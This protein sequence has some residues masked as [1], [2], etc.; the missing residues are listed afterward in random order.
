MAKKT[1]KKATRS[2]SKSASSPKPKVMKKA[3]ATGSKKPVGKFP[4][5][6]AAAARPPV[7][8]TYRGASQTSAPRQLEVELRVDVDESHPQ[9]P[10]LNRVSYDLFENF[11]NNNSQWQVHRGSW[12]V[13]VPNAIVHSHEV[14]IS[15]IAR[16]WVGSQQINVNIRIMRMD[17]T[18]LPGPVEL[19]IEDAIGEARFDCEWKS[20]RF[21][22]VDLEV[23]ICKSVNSKKPILPSY[24]L[25][26]HN[27]RPDEIGQ[28]VLTIEDAYTEAGVAIEISS[29]NTV[30]DDSDPQFDSWSA[31]ELHE[32][33]VTHFEQHKD[34]PQWKLWG[35]LAGMYENPGVGG[36]MFDAAAQF[37]GAGK[38]PERQGF[39]VFRNHSWFNSL[40]AGTPSTQAQAEAARKYLYTWVHEAGHAFNFLHSWDKTRPDALSWMNYDW[41]YDQRNGSDTFW[42]RFLFTFDDSELLHLRH[43]NRSAVIMGGDSW[44]SGGHLESEVTEIVD[45]ELVS[46]EP[47]VEVLLRSAEWFQFLEPV[48]IEIRLR[49]RTSKPLDV[50]TNV[51]PEFGSVTIMIKSPDG[52]VKQYQPLMCKLVEVKKRKLMSET[53]T[54]TGTDRYSR[55]ID[56]TFGE[57]GFYFD[58]PGRYTI[59]AF[60]QG[61]DGTIIPSNS[62]HISVGYPLTPQNERLAQDYFTPEVGLMIYLNGSRSPRLEKALDVLKE[63]SDMYA[64]DRLAA[65]TN[66]VIAEA[67]GKP[68]FEVKDNKLVQ[69]QGPKP[70]EALEM[71]DAAMAVFAASDQESANLPHRRLVDQRSEFWKAIGEP[72]KVKAEETVLCSI[73]KKRGVNSSVIKDIQKQK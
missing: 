41:K 2:R 39:A 27:N 9:S 7:S 6:L 54:Q 48:S 20:H 55:L 61:L 23:D 14:A 69:K 10:T 50:D 63:V 44:A 47:P 31:A 16:S 15:G 46:G 25:H 62:H 32:A 73:L 13:D 57:D 24:D 22:N 59:R 60:Y 65:K 11:T 40:V 5:G 71:T 51:D 19:T 8:G 26:T 72:S 37:G 67:V 18:T 38:A 49:N 70:E 58:R 43:G 30:I 45:M 4:P 52:A 35:L 66:S 42:K 56:L 3:K 21:R 28:R 33:M 12:I 1:R 64:K 68:F 17:S 29:D 34:S 36:V 53:K